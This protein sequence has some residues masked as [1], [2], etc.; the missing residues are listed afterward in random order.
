L[1]KNEY[2]INGLHKKLY[3]STEAQIWFQR[4]KITETAIHDLLESIQEAIAKKCKSDWNF[5]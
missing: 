4:R 2:H 1:T 3:G 5:L